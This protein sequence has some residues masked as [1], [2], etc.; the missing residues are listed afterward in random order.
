MSNTNPTNNL[1]L[2]PGVCGSTQVLVKDKNALL[3]HQSHYKLSSPANVGDR[4]N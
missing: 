2:N 3:R 1:W 4:G